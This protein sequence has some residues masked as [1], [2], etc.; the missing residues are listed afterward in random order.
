MRNTHHVRELG[1]LGE[2]VA[3]DFLIVRGCRIIVANT[4][5]DGGEID[6]VVRDGSTTVAVEV[7]ATTD[8]SNPIDAVDDTK[9][10]LVGRTA[11]GSRF[12]IG[13]IDIVGVRF[14][15]SGVE[16]RWLRGPD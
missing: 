15:K 1:R 6:L 8:G 3:T 11:A 14:D 5:A 10:D 9:M 13:R 16:I 7:K 12:R 4:R 2:R